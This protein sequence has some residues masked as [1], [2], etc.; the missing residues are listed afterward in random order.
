MLK[1]KPLYFLDIIKPA[2]F[3]YLFNYLFNHIELTQLF[4]ISFN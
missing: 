2:L 4:K 3:N 1:L